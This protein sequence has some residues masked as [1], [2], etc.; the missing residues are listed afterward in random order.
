MDPTYFL[1]LEIVGKDENDVPLEIHEV[2]DTYP[3]G[4][5]LIDLTEYNARITYNNE[6]YIKIFYNNDKKKIYMYLNETDYRIY[7]LNIRQI[8]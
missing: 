2:T 7:A 5:W 8:S 3:S 6:N 4:D 1:N